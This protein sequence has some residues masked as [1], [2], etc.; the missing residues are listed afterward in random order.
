MTGQ[1]GRSRVDGPLPRLLALL[2]AVG[3]FA[4]IGVSWRDRAPDP[5]A[6][7]LP[8]VMQARQAPPAAATA[9]S[10]S[11]KA[12]KQ[13]ELE[14]LKAAGKLTAEQSMMMRQ[15]IARECP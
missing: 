9:D 5:A 15:A 11:C 8:G 2:V 6:T 3:C 12:R 1:R 4:A 7:P 10:G 14:Q 13:A